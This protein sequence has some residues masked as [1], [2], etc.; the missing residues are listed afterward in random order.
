MELVLYENTSGNF[1]PGVGSNFLA[2]FPVTVQSLDQWDTFTLPT[3][4]RYNGPGDVVVGVIALEL[5]GTSYWPAAQDQNVSQQRSWVGAWLSSP[6]PV[7]PTIPADDLWGLI[8]NFGFVGNWLVRASGD[9]V[10]VGGNSQVIDV[11]FDASQVTQPGTYTG[12]VKAKTNDPVGK[13]YTVDVTMNVN[14]PANW[15]QLQG[16]VTGL[17]YCDANPAPLKDALV[18]IE[19]GLSVKTD[20]NGYYLLWL[21]EGTYNVTVTARMVI[22]LVLPQ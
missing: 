12:Q 3:P 19:G 5:P 11:T 15:G 2:S 14:A 13:T 1:D 9:T 4:V 10:P 18:S 8:D 22:P 20:A 16:T 17:G 21:E 6:P 7:P